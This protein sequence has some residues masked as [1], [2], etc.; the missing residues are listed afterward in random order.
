MK[1]EISSSE[2]VKRFNYLKDEKRI[3]V[4][5][6]ASDCGIAYVY[7]VQILKGTYNKNF[8]GK[9]LI[10]ANKYM[11]KKETKALLSDFVK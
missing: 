7:F 5:K 11:S 3:E 2:L 4:K 6:I 1:K 8:V 10:K 9:S